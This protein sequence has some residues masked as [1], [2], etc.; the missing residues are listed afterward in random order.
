MYTLLKFALIL[1][2]VAGLLF[3]FAPDTVDKVATAVSGYTGIEK[4]SLVNGTKTMTEQTQNLVDNYMD[5]E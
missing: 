3:N 1:A 2:I 4:E 5:V